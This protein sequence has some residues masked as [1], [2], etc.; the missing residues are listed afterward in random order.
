ISGMGNFVRLVE[1]RH[2]AEL[3]QLLVRLRKGEAALGRGNRT[4]SRWLGALFESLGEIGVRD[5]LFAD[6]AGEQLLDLFESLRR[7]LEGDPL[8]IDFREW[9]RWLSRQLEAATFRDRAI[10]SPVVFTTLAATQLR[11]FDAVLILGADAAHL[12]G[13]DP[14]SR[15]FNQGVR[16]ELGLSTWAERVH[17]MEDQLAA[18]I[19]ATDS[20]VVTWQRMLGGDENLL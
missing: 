15:F 12:P 4:L 18:L 16:G 13:P 1:D 2:D 11:S 5:G 8:R 14:V 10:E 3:R 7:D 20:T 6:S 19:A 17:E 9:R